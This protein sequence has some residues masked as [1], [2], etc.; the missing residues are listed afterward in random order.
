ML[1]LL[2][3]LFRT[4]T[5]TTRVLAF[6]RLCQASSFAGSQRRDKGRSNE[7]YQHNEENKME[8]ILKH[9]GNVNN[10]KMQLNN[11]KRPFLVEAM[12]DANKC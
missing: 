11:Q 2:F 4:R 5:P 9:V 8:I 12:V 10:T 3:S 1:V 6:E 7:E